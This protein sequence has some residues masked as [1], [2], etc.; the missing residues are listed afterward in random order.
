[1]ALRWCEKRG[2]DRG[3]L[4][5]SAVRHQ[6]AVSGFADAQQKAGLWLQHPDDFAVL[7]QGRVLHLCSTQGKYDPAR[8]QHWHVDP[9][10]VLFWHDSLPAPPPVPR[11]RPRLR[12]DRRCHSPSGQPGRIP[13]LFF[14]GMNA[15]PSQA[16]E[17]VGRLAEA[18][19]R[20]GEDLTADFEFV[21]PDATL[22]CGTDQWNAIGVE[23][24]AK[25][26]LMGADA[27]NRNVT[28]VRREQ[29]TLD[30]INLFLLER[31]LAPSDIIMG[32][33]SQGGF[34]ATRLAVRLPR[35]PRAAFAVNGAFVPPLG[36]DTSL[37]PRDVLFAHN[38]FDHV[39]S[40]PLVDAGVA[41]LRNKGTRVRVS[42][43]S[44]FGHYESAQSVDATLD[45]LLDV[46]RERRAQACHCE[47]CSAPWGARTTSAS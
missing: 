31:E 36:A 2:W 11:P 1:M 15:A 44:D 30:F 35:P 27:V 39:V 13:V 3:G 14:H 7:E 4:L 47:H 32:G 21:C 8:A 29:K 37:Y 33:I 17:F 38:R 42:C 23:T 45:L 12:A 20:V 26:V 24:V 6:V 28:M 22:V 40:K 34:A 5:R 41:A 9:A 18:A 19:A 16:E 10:C 46:V 43:C 25:Y